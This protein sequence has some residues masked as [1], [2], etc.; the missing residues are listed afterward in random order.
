MQLDEWAHKAN[1]RDTDI[2][3][4]EVDRWS[5]NGKR[6]VELCLECPV[7]VKCLEYVR[8]VEVAGVAAGMTQTQR[9]K[10]REAQGLDPS[11]TTPGI[12]ETTPDGDLESHHL[13]DLP[14]WKPKGYHEYTQQA[15]DLV[16]RLTDAGWTAARITALVN[17]EEF[18]DQSVDY[19][20]REKG[21][22][23][24]LTAMRKARNRQGLERAAAER[25]RRERLYGAA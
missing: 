12:W 8:T 11:P 1:C 24:K 4:T 5:T 6:A 25:E 17:H 21:N 3:F 14:L 20:R 13:V 18:G 7:M 9:E 2:D 19:I 16:F 23:H 15:I 22:D 10:W